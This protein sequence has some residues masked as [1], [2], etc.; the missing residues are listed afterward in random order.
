MREITF[1][2]Y[3][4]GRGF[5]HR[6]D[7]RFKFSELAAWSVL[8]LAGGPAALGVT[9]LILLI[10]HILAGSRPALM[11][12]PLFFWAAMAAVIILTSGFS[13]PG[14]PLIVAGRE[15]PVSIDGLITGGI[16]AARLLVMLLAGQLLAATTDPA[17]LSEAL[18][19]LVFFLPRRWSGALASTISLTLSFLPV[20]LDEAASVRD[21][22]FSRGLGGR[23]SLFRR[24]LSLGL[25]LADAALRRADLTAEALLSRSFTDHPTPRE[26]KAATADWIAFA[27]VIL[28]PL[29]VLLLI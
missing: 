24:A 10:L 8:A 3:R 27:L 18:R 9:G 5:W 4:P 29:L 26:M 25:P 1:L 15:M 23:R 13:L 21:A 19:R 28:P 7:P 12:R 16:R 14:R 2:H 20:M 22:A 6:H 11:R 17:D